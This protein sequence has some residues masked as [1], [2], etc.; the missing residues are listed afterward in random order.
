MLMLCVCG[1]NAQQTTTDHYSANEVTLPIGGT[2][3]VTLLV[4]L[5]AERLYT[6]ASMDI[7]LPNGVAMDKYRGNWDAYVNSQ[8][9]GFDGRSTTH[10]VTVESHP[11]NLYAL[12]CASLNIDNFNDTKGLL[13]LVNLVLTDEAKAG[14]YDLKITNGYLTTKEPAVDYATPDT[15]VKLYITGSTGIETIK[16]N[17]SNVLYSV[18]GVKTAVP[19]KGRLYISNGKKVIL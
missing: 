6:A 1:I 8:C 16:E 3:A 17:T 18:D 10:S 11:N 15:T 2:N 5:D 13:F 12:T 19:Q 7:V 9:L 4:S 14:E